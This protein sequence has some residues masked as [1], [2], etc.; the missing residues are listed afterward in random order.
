MDEKRVSRTGWLYLVIMELFILTNIVRSLLG[1]RGE[2]SV[3]LDIAVSQGMIILPVIIFSFVSGAGF[4]DTFALRTVRIPTLLLML[5]YVIMWYPLIAACNA[6]TMLFTENTAIEMS[7]DFEGINPFLEWLAVGAAG[8]LLEE[9]CFRGAI[10]SGLKKSG[11]VFAAV[12]LQALMFG[13]LHLNLNQMAYTIVLGTAF[14]MAV[15]VTGSIWCGVVGHMLVNSVSVISM[16]AMN[17]LPGNI[18]EKSVEMTDDP[19]WKSQMITMIPML[20]FL[21]I[22]VAGLSIFLLKAMAAI[23]R[24]EDEFRKMFTGRD[25]GVLKLKVCTLPAALGLLLG[26]I[27]ITIRLLIQT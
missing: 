24:R 5:L 12:L 4:K 14:G 20:L 9:F 25:R 17:S 11:R 7:Q 13:V 2:M 19:V 8:P 1:E 21:G 10:L 26:V 18:I 22:V 3:V 16:M 15:S 27:F 23:E 6:F